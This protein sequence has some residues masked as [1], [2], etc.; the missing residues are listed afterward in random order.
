M[1]S[2][3]Y[4]SARLRSFWRLEGVLIKETEPHHGCGSICIEELS[5][6]PERGCQRSAACT[7]TSAVVS[8][9]VSHVG[10]KYDMVSELG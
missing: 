6:K 3:S 2:S 7:L 9:V 1:K 8:V 4:I 10:V 5:I